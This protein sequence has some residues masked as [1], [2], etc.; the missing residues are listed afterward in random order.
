MRLYGWILSLGLVSAALAS[1][2]GEGLRLGDGDGAGSGGSGTEAGGQAEAGGA[3]GAAGAGDG[4]LGGFSSTGG[5]SSIGGAAEPGAGGALMPR[6]PGLVGHALVSGGA[7][8]RSSKYRL[9]VSMG[10]SPG[11]QGVMHS[12]KYRLESGVVGTSQ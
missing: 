9:W 8:L 11:A 1:G 12:R 10:E 6:T 7:L 4:G 5:V 2:C 3:P